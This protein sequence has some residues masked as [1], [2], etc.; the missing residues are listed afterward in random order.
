MS[1][2]INTTPQPAPMT[3]TSSNHTPAGT[4][5]NFLGPQR[6]GLSITDQSTIVATST[7]SAIKKG[8]VP[9]TDTIINS[10]NVGTENVPNTFRGQLRTYSGGATIVRQ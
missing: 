7:D 8:L 9:T 6:L 10:I 3:P 1:I 4:D 5:L 2:K